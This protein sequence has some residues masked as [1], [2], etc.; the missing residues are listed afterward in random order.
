MLIWS[1][2]LFL[3]VRCVYERCTVIYVADDFVLT[4][5]QLHTV[6]IALN[7]ENFVK[8]YLEPDYSLGIIIF[9]CFWILCVLITKYSSY[10]HGP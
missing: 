9:S 7:V 10:A 3:C 8:K 2:L 1:A 6:L 4:N 5:P